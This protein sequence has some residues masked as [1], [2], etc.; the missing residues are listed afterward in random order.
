MIYIFSKTSDQVWITVGSN[1][2]WVKVIQVCSNGRR[3]LIHVQRGDNH[4]NAKM[5]QVHF[6]SN[7]L[8]IHWARNFQI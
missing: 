4:K 5:G 7:L 6:K 2:P 1:H 8:K 3:G